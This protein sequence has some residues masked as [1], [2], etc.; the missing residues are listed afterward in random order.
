VQ[1]HCHGVENGSRVFCCA[2][3]VRE[4][5]ETGCAIVFKPAQILLGINARLQKKVLEN[6]HDK[7][8]FRSPA[9]AGWP[10]RIQDSKNS[11]A[12]GFLSGIDGSARL[13]RVAGET[14]SRCHSSCARLSA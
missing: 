6:E 10:A 5:G 7:Y 14:I 1:K 11:S 3:C 9:D 4:S 13:R 8:W 2:N 12:T